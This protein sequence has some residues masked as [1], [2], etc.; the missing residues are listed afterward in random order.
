MIC[1]FIEDHS[2]STANFQNAARG[3][4]IDEI[5]NILAGGNRPPGLLL[6]ALMPCG[7]WERHIIP[8]GF[9]K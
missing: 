7:R 4:N 6:K 3:F 8:G 5:K 2:S 9:S 1:D